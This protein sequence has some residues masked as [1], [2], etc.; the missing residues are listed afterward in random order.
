MGITE[1][2]Q[3]GFGRKVVQEKFILALRSKTEQLDQIV[4]DAILIKD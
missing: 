1:G 2:N 3:S 4:Q